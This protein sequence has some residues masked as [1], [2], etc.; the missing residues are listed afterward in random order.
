[1]SICLIWIWSRVNSNLIFHSKMCAQTP[2]PQLWL[3]RETD[4]QTNRR[5]MEKKEREK[6]IEGNLISVLSKQ[7]DSL[8]G[9]SHIYYNSG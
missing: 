3:Q 7:K 6:R 2:V 1:M 5:A 8:A 4:G 9:F